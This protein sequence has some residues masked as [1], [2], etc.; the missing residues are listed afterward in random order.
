VSQPRV[1]AIDGAA[2]S[3]KSTLSRGLA[4]TLDLPYVNTGLMYRALAAAAIALRL[5]VDDGP[6]L[7]RVTQG[8]RFT[9]EDSA[10]HEL[11]VE[12]A[13]ERELF[14]VE[15][16]AV[17][18]TASAHKGVR[19][20]MRARQRSIGDTS[21]A[22][23]EGR[24]IASVVFPDAPLKLYLVADTSVRIA[25]RAAERGVDEASVADAMRGRDQRDA[26]TNPFRAAEG[27]IVLDTTDLDVEAALEAALAIARREAPWLVEGPAE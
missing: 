9:L 26:R 1:V 7:E 15:V 23:M 27:A 5:D 6:G 18:S 17:V 11:V 19:R 3:G 21:G 4:R 10:P 13:D 8:L 20:L 2:G 16:E 22:V 24:D 25:R 14:S 12:G